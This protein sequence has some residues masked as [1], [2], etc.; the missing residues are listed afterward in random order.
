MITATL[1]SKGQITIPKEI[2]E[3]LDLKKGDKIEFELSDEEIVT[4][5]RKSTRI[6][7]VSGMLSEYAD[8][9]YSIEEMDEA[10]EEMFRRKYSK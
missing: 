8:R 3:R 4:I 7:E 5:K 1:S 9:R 6:D 2:R 10:V